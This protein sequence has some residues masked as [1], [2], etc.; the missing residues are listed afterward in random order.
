MTDHDFDA[1]SNEKDKTLFRS[2]KRP[3][4][5]KPRAIMV[6]CPGVTN[7]GLFYHSMRDNCYSC[8][9]FWEQYPTCPVHGTKLSSGL[10][11][12]QCKKYYAEPE[13]LSFAKEG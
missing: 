1:H 4:R 12:R 11:C 13:R 10:F 7:E 3:M 5:T 2:I 8:A 6:P 9:P